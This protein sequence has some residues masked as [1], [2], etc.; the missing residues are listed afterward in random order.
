MDQLYLIRRTLGRNNSKDVENN[1]FSQFLG[2]LISKHVTILK[3]NPHYENVHIPEPDTIE[4]LEQKFTYVSE[5]S[6]HFMKVC[7][8]RIYRS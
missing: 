4:P 8:Y 5:Q 3:S 1:F 2:N 6:L 7:R